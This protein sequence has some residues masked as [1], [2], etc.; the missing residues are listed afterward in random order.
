M[1][2]LINRIRLR[3]EL[4][5]LPKFSFENRAGKF[6]QFTLM[7]PRLS[8][9][10]DRIPI[11]I[12]E[13]LLN[14]LDLDGGEMLAISGIV[15][16]N[17]VRMENGRRLYIFV[18]ATDI[19]SEDGDPINE[20][21]LDGTICREPIYRR[22][23]LGREICDVMLAVDRAFHRADFLPCILWGRTARQISSCHTRDVI[24]I[25]GRFQSR[26]YT[27]VT[28]NGPQERTAYEISAMTA[29]VLSMAEEGSEQE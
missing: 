10:V 25:S 26:D 11:I 29:E 19:K 8:G 27:K 16:S 18:L 17:T 15:R 1:E 4:V 7:V 12:Q 14:E 2:Q 28:D 21:V 22:T 24:R 9:T 20:V 23:P 13:Q 6:Y 3:G 5:S